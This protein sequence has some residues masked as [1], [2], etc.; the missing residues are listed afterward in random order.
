MKG[1]ESGMPC[2]LKWEK[3]FDADEIVGKLINWRDASGTVG[4]KTLGIG[5]CKAASPA[6]KDVCPH[7]FQPLPVPL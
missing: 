2:Q 6:R 7:L 3:F 5:E 4:S 1:R